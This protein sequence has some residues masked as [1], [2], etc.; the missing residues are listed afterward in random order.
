M[1][2]PGLEAAIQVAGS[3]SALAYYLEISPQAV[4]KWERIP[5]ERAR[6]IH[7]ITGVPLYKL[8]PDLWT[9]PRARR[10]PEA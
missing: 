3:M 10:S 6:A 9:P 1:R 7:A 2:D 4:A 8:R 5:A